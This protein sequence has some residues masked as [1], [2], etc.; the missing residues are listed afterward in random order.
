MV[1][2]IF[3]DN[4]LLV[5]A[6]GKGGAIYLIGGSATIRD[7]EFRT[8]RVHV[9]YGW[10]ANTVYGGALYASAVDSL[11]VSN[12]LFIQHQLSVPSKLAYGSVLA[13]ENKLAANRTLIEDCVLRLPPP[14]RE[15][16]HPEKVEP[17]SGG[18]RIWR[19]PAPPLTSP[20][21]NRDT[22]RVRPASN[23]FTRAR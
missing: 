17:Y 3:H 22:R 8:N 14:S 23:A 13:I 16:S 4:P 9:A 20:M 19:E 5:Y 15:N 7:C 2:T 10:S 11:V 6:T 21:S 18:G 1:D 12:C